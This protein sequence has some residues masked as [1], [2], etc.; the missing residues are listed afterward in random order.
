MGAVIDNLIRKCVTDL[1]VTGLTITHDMASAR[2]ISDRIAMLYQGRI[3][4]AGPTGEIDHCGNPFVE[5]FIH[6]CADGPIRML[7]DDSIG[8]DSIAGDTIS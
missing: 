3:I 2:R 1:G 4:W 8:G 7:G 6:G 5:Q